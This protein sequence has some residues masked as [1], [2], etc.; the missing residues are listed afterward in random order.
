MEMDRVSHVAARYKRDVVCLYGPT[1]SS[2][3]PAVIMD[4][5]LDSIR[6]IAMVVPR[7]DPGRH[8]NAIRLLLRSTYLITHN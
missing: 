8:R 2:L 6:A 1:P 4:Q 3:P 7:G 5:D